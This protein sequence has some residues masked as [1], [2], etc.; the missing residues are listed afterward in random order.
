MRS[1]ILVFRYLISTNPAS[2]AH[3]SDSWV[4]GLI[5]LSLAGVVSSFGITFWRKKLS[6]S[7]TRKL[8]ASWSTMAFWMGIIGLVLVVARVERIQIL[9][10]PFLWVIWGAVILLY[11]IAQW[12]LFVMKH[13]EVM[14]RHLEVDPKDRY[15]PKKKK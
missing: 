15:L 11:V 6:N 1:L 2:I 8:S 13:Y 12:R 4:I 9:A 5:L 10:M 14:P 7:V 3:Y